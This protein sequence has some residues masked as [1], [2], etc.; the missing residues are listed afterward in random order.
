MMVVGLVLAVPQARREMKMIADSRLLAPM[1]RLQGLCSPDMVDY[2]LCCCAAESRPMML[3]KEA[4]KK[5]FVLISL[6]VRFLSYNASSQTF[7]RTLQRDVPGCLG[8]HT[9]FRNILT[10]SCNNFWLD[11]DSFR[12]EAHAG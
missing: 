7:H 9:V 11:Q 5:I 10:V 12:P 3:S 4:G 6:F 2:M 8:T 1:G